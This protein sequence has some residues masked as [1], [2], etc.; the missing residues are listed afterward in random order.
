M[1]ES[2]LH[3]FKIHRKVIFGN[4][5]IIVQNM[6]RI[7]PKPFDAVDVVLAAVRKRFAVVQPVVFAPAP[8]GVV[9]P[10]RISVVHRSFS[11]MFPDVRHEL[12]SRYLLNYFG[13]YPPIAF[14]EAQNNAFS[15]APRPRFPLRLPPK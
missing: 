13:V 12:G 7:T 3:L 14:Q 6:L 15:A 5:P 8:Q 2:V 10:E 9:A 11:G 4:T 1:I